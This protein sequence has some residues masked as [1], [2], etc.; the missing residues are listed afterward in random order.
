MSTIISTIS[1]GISSA[2]FLTILLLFSMDRTPG[3]YSAIP[4]TPDPF[5][6]ALRI[7]FTIL[8]EKWSIQIISLELPPRIYSGV[9]PRSPARVCHELLEKFFLKLLKNFL[10]DIPYEVYPGISSRGTLE[11]LTLVFFF[12]NTPLDSSG[13]FSTNSFKISFTNCFRSFSR[14]FLQE[15]LFE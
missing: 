4:L 8:L 15:A 3:I 13:S 10:P 5:E 9:P 14:K 2:S 1:L 12:K 6:T 7:Y 11:I